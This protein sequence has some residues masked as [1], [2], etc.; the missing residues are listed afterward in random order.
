MQFIQKVLLVCAS[1]VALSACAQVKH[2]AMELSPGDSKARVLEIM[3]APDDRQ[4]NGENEALQYG[5]VVSIGVCD[6]TVVWLHDGK[7]SGITS[8]RH[9]STM[10]CRQGLQPISWSEAPIAAANPSAK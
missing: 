6:Y 2:K 10:G 7:T 4:F 1:A 8:Y 3:G 5:M 9:F